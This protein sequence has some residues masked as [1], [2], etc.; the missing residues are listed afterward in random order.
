MDESRHS[1]I[2]GGHHILFRQCCLLYD[3]R[4]QC[5]NGNGQGIDLASRFVATVSGVVNSGLLFGLDNATSVIYKV[6]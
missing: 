5:L 3:A 2:F 6:I 1:V 4:E